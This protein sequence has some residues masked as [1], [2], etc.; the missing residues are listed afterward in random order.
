MSEQP[1]SLQRVSVKTHAHTAFLLSSVRMIRKHQNIGTDNEGIGDV[2]ALQQA[3]AET[4][5]LLSAR[6][7]ELDKAKRQQSDLDVT[8]LTLQGQLQC[9]KRAISYLRT[10]LYED[11]QSLR[12][13][14]QL[15]ESGILY[16]I[17]NTSVV[18][19]P[20]PPTTATHTTAAA[21]DPQT[22]ADGQQEFPIPMSSRGNTKVNIR[23]AVKGAMAMPVAL[24]SARGNGSI[25]MSANSFP[26]FSNTPQS[27]AANV[28]TPQLQ[29]S[30]SATL[31]PHIIPNSY[32]E[33]TYLDAFKL[34]ESDT[35]AA[36]DDMIKAAVNAAR[37]EMKNAQELSR[38]AMDRK[39]AK[40]IVELR[41]IEDA[42]LATRR[43]LQ[44]VEVQLEAKSEELAVAIEQEAQRLRELQE[45]AM[46]EAKKVFQDQIA[47]MEEKV[48]Q[49]AIDSA[50]ALAEAEAMKDECEAKLADFD[51]MMVAHKKE[52]AVLKGA[53]SKEREEA[54]RAQNAAKAAESER[55]DCDALIKDLREKLADEKEANRRVLETVGK[56]QLELVAAQAAASS[57]AASEYTVQQ[58]TKQTKQ[59]K[60]QVQTLKESL[61][62][63]TTHKNVLEGEVQEA[64]ES[65]VQR[66]KTE[67]ELREKLEKCYDLEAEMKEK[68]REAGKEAE[69]SFL[70]QSISKANG[71]ASAELQLAL[72][73]ALAREQQ[74]KDRIRIASVLASPK[75]QLQQVRAAFSA[76]IALLPPEVLTANG[77]PTDPSNTPDRTIRSGIEKLY[78]LNNYMDAAT[79][80][81]LSTGP[82]ISSLPASAVSLSTQAVSPPLNATVVNGSGVPTR[83]SSATAAGNKPTPRSE[84]AILNT[85]QAPERASTPV[86]SEE[87]AS[88][89]RVS[90][91][92]LDMPQ[93]SPNGRRKSRSLHPPV[94]IPSHIPSRYSSRGCNLQFA[95]PKTDLRSL[96]TALS[97]TAPS[98]QAAPSTVSTADAVEK[99]FRDLYGELSLSDVQYLDSMRMAIL[100]SSAEKASAWARAH[101]TAILPSYFASAENSVTGGIASARQSQSE[102]HLAKLNSSRK[103]KSSGSRSHSPN[104]SKT[105][106]NSNNN[107]TTLAVD[108]ESSEVANLA[109]QRKS[110]LRRI[111]STKSASSKRASSASSERSAIKSDDKAGSLPSFRRLGPTKS[112]SRPSTASG[113]KASGVTFTSSQP[114]RPTSAQSPTRSGPQSPTGMPAQSNPLQST[115]S[116]SHLSSTPTVT[117]EVFNAPS[118][119]NFG[120]TTL[121]FRK[122]PSLSAGRF[123]DD[124]L[125]IREDLSGVELRDV[126]C[127]WDDQD[128]LL[129]GTATGHRPMLQLVPSPIL[130]VAVDSH[131]VQTSFRMATES[132]ACGTSRP[133]SA[134]P[135]RTYSVV[136]QDTFADSRPQSAKVLTQIIDTPLQLSSS[137]PDGMV[138]P[139]PVPTRT[140]SPILRGISNLQ[141]LPGGSVMGSL[142]ISASAKVLP[143]VDFLT[144][145]NNNEKSSPVGDRPSSGTTKRHASPLEDSL[146]F[147]SP[148]VNASVSGSLRLLPATSLYTPPVAHA[149][150]TT[151]IGVQT[152]PWAP[153]PV[154]DVLQQLSKLAALEDPIPAA[155]PP[156]PASAASSVNRF[157]PNTDRQS[158]PL[159]YKHAIERSQSTT[160]ID[161]PVQLALPRPATAGSN[162]NAVY[163]LSTPP[164]VDVVL[165]QHPP[166]NYTSAASPIEMRRE[167][168]KKAKELAAALG[169]LNNES[170]VS[171]ASPGKLKRPHSA[172]PVIVS[173]GHGAVNR[174]G[175]SSASGARRQDVRTSAALTRKT[176]IASSQVA[177]TTIERQEIEAADET[178]L[179]RR[180]PLPHAV[181]ISEPPS[182][183]WGSCQPALQTHWERESSLV[184]AQLRE[185]LRPDLN[186]LGMDRNERH[187]LLNATKSSNQQRRPTTAQS[188]MLSR[189]K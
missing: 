145:N 109:D 75:D 39:L 31:P 166:L 136:T 137:S 106:S 77:D 152:M 184:A 23:K 111:T 53:I 178:H 160:S 62:E 74:L 158:L 15:L 108:E 12:R 95:M 73:E 139:D 88:S 27:P 180:D 82:I 61:E 128:A 56:V 40:A 67:A 94:A 116:A 44:T 43:N 79:M 104:S 5:L 173:F 102:P 176:P 25:N 133:P 149:V 9:K 26:S 33:F 81:L 49:S 4:A 86:A 24:N 154:V 142:R 132:V 165:D 85:S 36:T 113:T 103:G 126:A 174:S 148:K 181:P 7:E 68:L 98:P 93:L 10:T 28:P 72:A 175:V 52:V 125:L 55:E 100:M 99:T 65:L 19:V 179:R 83:P 30:P 34:I 114:P 63:I 64:H 8:V 14:T 131:S 130:N 169:A 110:P 112:L 69:A 45:K 187:R 146:S 35:T 101:E 59:L 2:L 50:K 147:R 11:L 54:I 48:R 186:V 57:A 60:T 41:E 153:T 168:S 156:R 117:S 167:M 171:S 122:T 144:E 80:A 71:G 22:I 161:A 21:L 76:L 66:A 29:A 6:T 70:A 127:Q 183:L 38:D 170:E 135:A 185:S 3:L 58:L 87:A 164:V 13:Q 107:L 172:A 1:F 32:D 89:P 188:S 177:T 155:V 157:Y 138:P 141:S 46:A 159:G 51:A 124:E 123:E 129:A 90:S 78:E 150:E 92:F 151:E 16:D 115:L 121:P 143:T 134:K 17:Q 96:P 84:S 182:A 189:L 105:V 42:Y 47:E 119:G 18:G 20:I 140:A 162:Y 120:N 97:T 91:P 118:T 37:A 163:R